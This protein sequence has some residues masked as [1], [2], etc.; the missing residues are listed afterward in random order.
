ARVLDELFDEQ[1]RRAEC[2]GRLP[3]RE[4]PRGIELADRR[5]RAHPLTATAACG[6]QHHRVA[7][8]FRLAT[9]VIQA[10]Q[11]FERA[12]R[13]RDTCLASEPARVRLLAELSLHV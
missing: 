1:R 4:T 8:A 13:D 11:R 6:L 7:D 12:L 5:D 10:L 3:R 9:R 2:A